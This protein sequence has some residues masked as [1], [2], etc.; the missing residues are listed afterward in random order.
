MH[1]PTVSTSGPP[2]IVRIGR[3]QETRARRA[4]CEILRGDSQKI[5]A[6]MRASDTRFICIWRT[7]PLIKPGESLR[8]QWVN[9][10]MALP[11]ID[12]NG[13]DI[14]DQ[15]HVKMILK[16]LDMAC[17]YSRD[18]QQDKVTEDQIAK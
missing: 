1:L 18:G 10:L 15:K 17:D 12:E 5:D 9:G 13:T 16:D 2:G 4:G 6:M 3:G 11:I 8:I 14:I 7:K